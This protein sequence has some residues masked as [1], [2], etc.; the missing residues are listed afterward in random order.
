MCQSHLGNLGIRSTQQNEFKRRLCLLRFVVPVPVQPDLDNAEVA[1]SRIE[2]G[3][4][5]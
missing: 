5:D 4:K 2:L 3:P 1:Q